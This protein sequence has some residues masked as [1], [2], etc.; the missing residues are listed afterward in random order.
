MYVEIEFKKKK[1]K[2]FDFE[3]LVLRKFRKITAISHPC[4]TVS[5]LWYTKVHTHSHKQ[6]YTYAHTRTNT[7]PPPSPPALPNRPLTHS[8]SHLPKLNWGPPEAAALKLNPAPPPPPPPPEGAPKLKPEDEGL[9]PPAP[10]T[11]VDPGVAE[12]F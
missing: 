11:N 10:N 12:L 3:S 9:A 6:T 5:L 4:F 2:F 1:K 7:C 8:H